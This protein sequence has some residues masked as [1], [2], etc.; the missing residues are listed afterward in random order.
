[1]P[2]IKLIKYVKINKRNFQF[3]SVKNI[4]FPEIRVMKY[5][6]IPRKDSWTQ[7]EPYTYKI[8]K[9]F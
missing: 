9:Y 5:I 2:Q 3:Q 7:F 6:E 8:T 1:M 4:S